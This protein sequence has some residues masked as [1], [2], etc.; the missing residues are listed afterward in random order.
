MRQVG[1]GRTK[2]YVSDSELRDEADKIAP[3]DISYKQY[4]QRFKSF[5]ISNLTSRIF[6]FFKIFILIFFRIHVLFNSCKFPRYFTTLKIRKFVFVSQKLLI[7][8]LHRK[9]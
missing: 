4:C 3:E 9:L 6:L 5:F 7:L 1:E 8:I 2:V